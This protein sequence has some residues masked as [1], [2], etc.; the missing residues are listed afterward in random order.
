MFENPD[1]MKTQAKE[2]GNK[3]VNTA[4]WFLAFIPPIHPAGWPFIAAFAIATIVLT[5]FWEGFLT[6]GIILTLWCAFFFRNP[7]RVTPQ[8]PGVIV[9]PADGLVIK[10]EPSA[11]PSE[12]EGDYEGSYTKISIFLNVFDVHVQRVPLAGKVLEVIYRPGKFVNASFDKAS[13]DNERSTVMVEAVTG[14]K[15]AFV[16]I[17]G[18]VARR[19]INNLIAGQTVSAGEL[20]GLIRFGSRLDVYLPSNLTPLVSIGQRTI[21]GETVLAQIEQNSVSL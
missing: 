20:Y 14:Q 4:K 15:I 1:Q 18:L 13:E 3:I 5:I 7:P 8:R 21:C 2:C 16:Q 10:V 11:L 6:F 17:A 19:I 12:L 9:S